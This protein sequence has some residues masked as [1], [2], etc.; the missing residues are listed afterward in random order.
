[1]TSAPRIRPA[2][3]ADLPAIV[4]LNVESWRA[5]Y[6]PILPAAFFGARVEEMLAAKWARL[7]DP[8]FILLAGDGDRPDGFLAQARGRGTRGGLDLPQ[9]FISAFHVRP[10]R[11]GRGIGRALFA[12]LVRRLR[13]AGEDGVWL[14]VADGNP[15]AR[16]AYAALG[17]TEIAPFDDAIDGHALAARRVIWRWRKKSAE[18]APGSLDLPPRKP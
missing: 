1:M 11:K 5:T 8:G 10:D 3:V 14:E 6:R 9:P 13:D 2:T 4:R 18:N 16:A 17:G 15:G 12:A 7:P